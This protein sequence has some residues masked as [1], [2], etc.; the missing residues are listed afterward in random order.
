MQSR[1]FLAFD[2]DGDGLISFHEY[3]L[4][5]VFLG[6]HV[7]VRAGP[8]SC[9]SARTAERLPSGCRDCSHPTSLQFIPSPIHRAAVLQGEELLAIAAV[10]SQQAALAV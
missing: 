2:L 3:L 5:M 1:F 9:F 7:E 4:I 10:T 8:R 6:V